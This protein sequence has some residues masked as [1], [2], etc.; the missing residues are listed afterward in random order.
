MTFQE[1]TR[2]RRIRPA[3]LTRPAG[4]GQ[5]QSFD[6]PKVG[7]LTRLYLHFTITTAGTITTQNQYG[8]CSAVNNI[9]LRANSGLDII[10]ITGPGAEYLLRDVVDLMS[11]TAPQSQG[12]ST[13]VTA[14]TYTFD[15]VLPV[16]LNNRDET[17]LI[18]LQNEQTLT[19]L[20]VA[21]ES[22]AAVILT[23]GGTI[24]AA[25]CEVYMDYFEIPNDPKDMPDLSV[26][27]TLR[28][29]RL[30]IAASGD[31]TYNIPRGNILA[32]V[33]HLIGTTTFSRVILRAQQGNNIV[34]DNAAS[35]R[36]VWNSLRSGRDLSLAGTALTGFA[37][38]YFHDFLGPDGLGAY[39]ARR[40]YIDT[41]LLTDLA[42]IITVA[43]AGELRTMRREII[44]LR[45]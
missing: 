22:D 37:F 7:L 14:T 26:A 21:W 11:D 29:D 38:R 30:A 12:R 18:L 6:L 44:P 27:H 1:S 32:G 34:D 19:T 31:V 4:G 35:H 24:S 28:E 41:S 17:G 33:Y 36:A 25:T 43:A 10:N 42:S 5:T 2:L 45:S 15:V 20:Y 13:L 40:D 8:V 39:G 3:I 9:A 23:G 16:S